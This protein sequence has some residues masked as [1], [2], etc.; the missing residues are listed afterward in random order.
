MANNFS[1]HDSS[2]YIS[3]VSQ[4]NQPFITIMDEHAA[5]TALKG[6][7]CQVLTKAINIFY[8]YLAHHIT[9]KST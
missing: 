7:I 6:V 3:I 8:S 4:I 5:S 1:F 2:D 9:S